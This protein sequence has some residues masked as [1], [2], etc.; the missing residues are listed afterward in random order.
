M[1]SDKREIDMQAS[2]AYPPSGRLCAAEGWSRAKSKS[3]IRN[4]GSPAVVK[5]ERLAMVRVRNLLWPY[6]VQQHAAGGL[7]VRERS[8]SKKRLS[9][10]STTSQPVT[11][12]HRWRQLDALKGYGASP[13]HRGPVCP[14]RS[15]T[16]IQ[17]SGRDEY[18]EKYE[19]EADKVSENYEIRY[20]HRRGA[21][22][23]LID[24]WTKCAAGFLRRSRNTSTPRT[25]WLS[26]CSPVH[27]ET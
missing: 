7:P 9:R 21:P 17:P 26:S 18:I 15:P 23:E 27:E 12:P 3:S 24:L 11:P 2:G 22:S 25:T 19:A 8:G 14:S 10:S 6:S 13:A 16:V 4:R 1:A 20:A 5:E